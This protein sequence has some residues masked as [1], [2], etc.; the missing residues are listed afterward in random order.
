LALE[1][2]LYCQ[3]TIESGTIKDLGL[4]LS[5]YRELADDYWALNDLPEAMATYNKTHFPYTGR[6]PKP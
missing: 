3:R 1:Q 4:R 6:C 5:I 2:H